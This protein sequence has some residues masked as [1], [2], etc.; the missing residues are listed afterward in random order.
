MLAIAWAPNNII[1]RIVSLSLHSFENSQLDSNRDAPTRSPRLDAGKKTRRSQRFAFMVIDGDKKGVPCTLREFSEEGA[2]VTM[3][4]W[5]GIPESFALRVEP[6]GIL[7]D[8][9]IVAKRNNAIR[10]TFEGAS[11][12]RSR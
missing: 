8:C 10:V 3:G 12:A 9:R 11:P 2:L 1:V 4:G 7:Y 5:I 6:D